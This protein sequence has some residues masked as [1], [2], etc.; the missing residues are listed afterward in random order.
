MPYENPPTNRASA[1]LDMSA[2]YSG[3]KFHTPAETSNARCWELGNQPLNP[4][5]AERGFVRRL[6][7]GGHGYLDN[8]SGLRRAG[9][10]FASASIGF[11]A[12]GSSLGPDR[13]APWTLRR[14]AL[15]EACFGLS[16]GLFE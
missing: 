11:I 13:R 6:V 3:T 1:S 15:L 9:L 7:F 16:Q 14:C 12:C 4:L 8:G 5:V 10:F 2:D